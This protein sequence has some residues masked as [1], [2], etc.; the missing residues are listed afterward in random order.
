MFGRP[1]TLLIRGVGAFILTPHTRKTKQQ[2]NA[3]TMLLWS[4]EISCLS[5][6]Y[7]QPKERHSGMVQCILDR[8]GY[9]LN[10]SLAEAASRGQLYVSSRAIRP[11]L[12]LLT[13]LLPITQ[14]YAEFVRL[15][16]EN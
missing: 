14:Y 16:T 1:Y 6:W 2:H 11:R 7:G 5:W 8:T 12:W 15:D 10:V 9:F 3:A 4:D 13:L